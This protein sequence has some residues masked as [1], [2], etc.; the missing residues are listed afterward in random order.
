M[1]HCTEKYLDMN[2]GNGLVFRM[3]TDRDSNLTE[4]KRAFANQVASETKKRTQKS[5]LYELRTREFPLKYYGSLSVALAS[6][7][8]PRCIICRGCCKRFDSS[9]I[10]QVAFFWNLKQQ[11]FPNIV[12]LGLLPESRLRRHFLYAFPSFPRDYQSQRTKIFRQM[13]FLVITG[14]FC[15]FCGNQIFAQMQEQTTNGRLAKICLS[16]MWKIE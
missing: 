16:R 1:T 9:E 6:V 10:I 4:W 13:P 11:S 5:H 3:R 15:C 7:V 12:I 2:C 8:S 14:P